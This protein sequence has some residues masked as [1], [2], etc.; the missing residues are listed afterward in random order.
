[1]LA[2]RKNNQAVLIVEAIVASFLMLFAF[3]AATQ[4]FDASLRW[5]SSSTNDRL[6]AMVAERKLEELRATVR[7]ACRTQSFSSLTLDETDFAFPDAPGFLIDVRA[8]APTYTQPRTETGRAAI[9]PGFHSPSSQLFARAAPGKNAQKHDFWLTYAFTRDLSASAR[10]VEI[11]VK[12][13]SGGGRE[14]RLVSLLADGLGPPAATPNVPFPNLPV[15]ITGPNSLANP[16]DTGT[17]TVSLRLPSGADV[18]DVVALWSLAPDPEGAV[19][20]KPIDPNGRQVEVTRSSLTPAGSAARIRLA[21]KVRY[22]GQE[23]IG[24]SPEVFLP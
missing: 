14:F 23:I 16:G 8:Y 1:M 22:R 6:A 12:Y 21:A 3:L 11:I 19:I 20:I 9:P 18:D 4:L 17:F 13:G 24:Y 7:S 10:G 5:E 2:I 15:R